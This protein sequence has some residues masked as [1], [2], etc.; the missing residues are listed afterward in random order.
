MNA[1]LKTNRAG[2]V[3]GILLILLGLLFFAGNLLGVNVWGAVAPLFVI[4]VGAVFFVGMVIGG[5]GTGGLAIPGS[6]LVMLGLVM[7]AQLVM[8]HWES[9]AY[10]WSLFAVAGVGIGLV[11]FSWW[12]DKPQLKRPGYIL[13]LIG[14]ILFFAFGFFFELLFGLLGSNASGWVMPLGLI[15]LGVLLLVGRVIPWNELIDQLP[16]H[17]KNQM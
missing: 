12:S 16:P 2:F 11:I 8:D 17:N 7:L 9:F 15:A 10:A 14:L 13:I 4:A 3:G 6:I 1:T 5:K